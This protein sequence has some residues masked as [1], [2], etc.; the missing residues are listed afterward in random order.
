MRSRT[1]IELGGK[2]ATGFRVPAEVVEAL[3]SG[4]RPRVRDRQRAH[5]PQHRGRLRRS[6]HASPQRDEPHRRRS[7]RR[8]RFRGLSYSKQRQRVERIAD[9]KTAETRQRRIAKTI[10]ELRSG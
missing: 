2:T 4:K 7:R 10:D 9:A 1:T 3:K 5:G 8:R 6:V